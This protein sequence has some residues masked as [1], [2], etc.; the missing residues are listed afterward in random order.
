MEHPFFEGGIGAITREWSASVPG[1]GR[2]RAKVSPARGG[3]DTEQNT[4]PRT[5]PVGAT[6]SLVLAAQS[7]AGLPRLTGLDVPVRRGFYSHAPDGARVS[8]GG[9]VSQGVA[10]SLKFGHFWKESQR[11]FAP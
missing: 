8:W 6:C 9:P 10:L 5:Q 1:R 7:S 11:D 3:M 4:S 2:L